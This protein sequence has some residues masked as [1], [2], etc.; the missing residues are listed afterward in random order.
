MPGHPFLAA[1]L[2]QI[3]RSAALPTPNDDSVEDISGPRMLTRMAYALKPEEKLAIKILPQIHLN[4]PVFY[5]RV[6]PL[7]RNIYA[8]H[9]CAGD[10]R[11]NRARW[12]QKSWRDF[13][14]KGQ[15]P[16]PFETAGPTLP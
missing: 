3:A 9:I 10:W 14:P 5:P 11:T 7:A 2:E 15:L 12:W 8:R 1:L 4:P 13:G 16:N 6:G